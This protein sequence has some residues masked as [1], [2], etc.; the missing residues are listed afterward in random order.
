MLTRRS[1]CS[2]ARSRNGVLS[3]SAATLSLDGRTRSIVEQF[4]KF[5]FN[6]EYLVIAGGVAVVKTT[7]AA[8]VLVAIVHQ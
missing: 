2:V 3:V 7:L 5:P 6:V 4:K 1:S 8:A